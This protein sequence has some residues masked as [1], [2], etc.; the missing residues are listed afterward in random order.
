MSIA[1]Q[2]KNKEMA[3][4]FITWA[5]SADLAKQV[6]WPALPPLATRPGKTPQ[7]LKKFKKD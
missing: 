2:S 7:S 3:L 6:Y 1:Q 4:K 5:T